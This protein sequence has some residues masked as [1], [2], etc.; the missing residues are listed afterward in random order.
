MRRFATCA[1]FSLVVACA[2]G[3]SER[4]PLDHQ[5]IGTGVLGGPS[6]PLPTTAPSPS[7]SDPGASSTSTTTEP[8]AASPSAAP[9]G[10]SGTV[11]DLCPPKGQKPD[12]SR[13][14]AKSGC[15]SAVKSRSTHLSDL[16]S[17]EQL[18]ASMQSNAPEREE[19]VFRLAQ[20]YAALECSLASACGKA[21]DAKVGSDEI[22]LTEAKKKTD[23]FCSTMKSD[24]PKSKRHCP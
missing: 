12:L 11:A 16:R 18:L 1:M 9:S 5:P 4:K 3:L 8:V 14:A 17:N 22:P 20:G 7:T 23:D 19:L 15:K 21:R 2:P 24:F 6:A 10:A 13:L